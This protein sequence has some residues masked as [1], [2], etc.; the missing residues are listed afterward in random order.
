M[1]QIIKFQMTYTPQ[2]FILK[3]LLSVLPSLGLRDH[4]SQ[5]CKTVSKIYISGG[6]SATE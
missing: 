3:L 4:I 1:A 5:Q 2:N 6:Y